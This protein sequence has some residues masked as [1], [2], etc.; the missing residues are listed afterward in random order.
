MI[1]DEK[2]KRCE[3][4]IEDFCGYDAPRDMDD[5]MTELLEERKQLVE[6]AKVSHDYLFSFLPDSEFCY[7]ASKV[8]AA[9]KAWKGN[10]ETKT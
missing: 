5:L 4:T 8:C 7:L 9:L 1:S 10:D 2:I 3:Q 6:I